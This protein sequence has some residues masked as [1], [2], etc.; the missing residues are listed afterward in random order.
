[1][2]DLALEVDVTHGSLRRLPIY[3]ALKVPEV[4]RLKSDVLTFHLLGA[5]GKYATATHSKAL[6]QVTPADLLGFVKQARQGGDLNPVIGQFRTWIRQRLAAGGG[7][8]PN[9]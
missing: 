6:P 7:S 2:P 4:W 9:P 8:S 3:A 1:P 5:D